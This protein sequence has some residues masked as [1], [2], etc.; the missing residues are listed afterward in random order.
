MNKQQLKAIERFEKAYHNLK[1]VGLKFYLHE[2]SGFVCKLS[3]LSQ[4]NDVAEE[5]MSELFYEGKAVSLKD[6]YV[7]NHNA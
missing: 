5:Y 3:D 2:S 4:N 6:V 7:D 1:E